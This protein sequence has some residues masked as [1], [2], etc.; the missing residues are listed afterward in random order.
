MVIHRLGAYQGRKDAYWIRTVSGRPFHQLWMGDDLQRGAS[1]EA[2][3]DR[4]KLR[5]LVEPKDGAE[6]HTAE[7]DKTLELTK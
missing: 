4:H 6:D 3:T 2:I 7:K 1:N 5:P